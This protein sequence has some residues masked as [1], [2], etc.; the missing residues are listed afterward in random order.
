MDNNIFIANHNHN[1]GNSDPIKLVEGLV[2][3]NQQLKKQRD[4]LLE[5]VADLQARVKGIPLP[6]GGNVMTD[7]EITKLKQELADAQRELGVL[8]TDIDNFKIWT[9]KLDWSTTD[10]PTWLDKY[11]DIKQ[12]AGVKST[13]TG[14][15]K[16][17]TLSGQQVDGVWHGPH[18]VF[19]EADQSVYTMRKVAGNTHGVRTVDSKGGWP[20]KVTEIFWMGKNL[21]KNMKKYPDGSASYM[22]ADDE[23]N[24]VTVGVQHKAGDIGTG[25]LLKNGYSVQLHLYKEEICLQYYEN[26][27]VVSTKW[28]QLKK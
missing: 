9:K 10:Q 16:A 14:S 26:S 19:A 2:K 8:K 18:T 24:G 5:T 17:I 15:T 21:Y 12:A 3:E 23:Y 6:G 13:F 20:G 4:S 27:Q 28:Y 7:A 22:C 1:Y 11:F 25:F